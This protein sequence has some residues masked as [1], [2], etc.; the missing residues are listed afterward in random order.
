MRMGPISKKPSQAGLTVEPLTDPILEAAAR[1][2]ERDGFD[3]VTIDDVAREARV[4][5]ATVYRR[6]GNRDSLFNA[7]LRY[8]A[9]SYIEKCTLIAQGP[10]GLEARIRAI[11]IESIASIDGLPWFRTMLRNGVSYRSLDI[12]RESHKSVTAGII[13]PMLETA[14]EIGDWEPPDD[15]CLLMDWL[16]REILQ[17]G[18]DECS[19]EQIMKRVSVYIMPVLRLSVEGGF[20]DRLS[21]IEN[22][23]CL[24]LT[25]KG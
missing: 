5:R 14:E 19:D 12:L 2:V 20:H 4:S 23:I 22:I 6:Y 8:A 25:G 1:C 3:G 11:I 15:I 7:L 16:L 9:R 18:S 24:R 17:I 10:G 21:T 13:R